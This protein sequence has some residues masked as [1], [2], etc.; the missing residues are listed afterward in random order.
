M[1]HLV[2]RSVLIGDVHAVKGLEELSREF[3]NI[4]LEK[5]REYQMNGPRDN[6][7]EN[8]ARKEPY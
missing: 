3:R 6:Y 2:Y 5:N 8:L 1:L 7:S 4:V